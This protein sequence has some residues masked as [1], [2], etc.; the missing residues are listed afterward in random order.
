MH[1]GRCRDTK[2]DMRLL[3]IYLNDHLAAVRGERALVRRCR[4][5][6]EGTALGDWL[7]QYAE[8]LADDAGEIERLMKRFGVRRSRVKPALAAAAE[9][10]GR[11]KLNGQLSGYSPLSRVVELE[12]MGAAADLR[13]SF[14][15]TLAETVAEPERTSCERRAERALH[16][17]TALEPRRAQAARIA[18]VLSQPAAG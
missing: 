14:W 13:R 8:E 2:L 4:D 10:A 3:G 7:G 15:L 6:N 16:Q 18:L 17:R 1:F 11:L 9:R 12:A 5:E